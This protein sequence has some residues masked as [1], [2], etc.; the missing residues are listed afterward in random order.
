MNAYGEK[1]HTYFTDYFIFQQH[2]QTYIDK[3]CLN[4]EQLL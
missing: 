4:N 1:L 3:E 2:R